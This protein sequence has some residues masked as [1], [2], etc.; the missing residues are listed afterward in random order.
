MD[1]LSNRNLIFLTLSAAAYLSKNIP[2]SAQGSKIWKVTGSLKVWIL[3]S[4]PLQSGTRSFRYLLGM[5]LNYKKFLSFS[6][7]GC[8]RKKFFLK[9]SGQWHSI[10]FP[11]TLWGIKLFLW[12]CIISQEGLLSFPLYLH[13]KNTFLSFPKVFPIP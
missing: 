9:G 4:A 1:F 8:L 13:Y 3:F 2:M 12:V 10:D 11:S 6:I 7:Q 5:N